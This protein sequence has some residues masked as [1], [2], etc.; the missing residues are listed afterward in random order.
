MHELVIIHIIML[1][2]QPMYFCSTM[3]HV[4]NYPI[5]TVGPDVLSTVGETAGGA[6]QI[7]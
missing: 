2:G 1:H 4:H 7:R 3:L 6:H 5:Y